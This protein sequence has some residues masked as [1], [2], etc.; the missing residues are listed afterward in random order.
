M[1]FAAR[2]GINWVYTPGEHGAKTVFDIASVEADLL[3]N[4]MFATLLYVESGK[5]NLLAVTCKKSA[6]PS[7]WIH[8]R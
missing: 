7:C 5:I 2:T 6:T 4:G 1:L 8:P 3:F